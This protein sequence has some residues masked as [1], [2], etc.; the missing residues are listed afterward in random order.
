LFHRILNYNS[1]FVQS[2]IVQIL[3]GNEFREIGHSFLYTYFTCDFV[4]TVHLSLYT[5]SVYCSL[6]YTPYRILFAQAVTRLVHS[7][8]HG[9]DPFNK[10]VLAQNFRCQ[11][12]YLF[13]ILYCFPDYFCDVNSHFFLLFWSL[14]CTVKKRKLNFP[15][16][17]GNLEGIGCK[18]IYD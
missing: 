10:N 15:H 4:Y 3:I 14:S 11:T 2:D 18:V 17:S 9:W 12:N 16:S 5:C 8:S 7:P 6:P 13:S 1:F